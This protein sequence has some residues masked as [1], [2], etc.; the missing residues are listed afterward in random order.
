MV[1]ARGMLTGS[2][3]NSDGMQNPEPEETLRRAAGWSLVL[4][5]LFIAY[6]SLYPFEFDP[7]RLRSADAQGWLASFAWRRPVR[8]DLIANLLFYLPFGA[9]TTYLAPQRWSNLRRWMLALCTGTALSLFIECAQFATRDRVPALSDVA[10]NGLS[11][12]LASAAVLGAHGLGVR[13]TLPQLRTHRPDPIALLLVALWLAFHCA[14]FMPT[15]RFLRYFN[16]PDLLLGQSVPVSATA[17][18]F[19]GY[20]IIGAALRNLLRPSSFWPVMASVAAVSLFARIAFRGQQLELAECVGLALALPLVWSI[21]RDAESQVYLK[22]AF[23]AATAVVVFMLAPFDFSSTTPTLYGIPI[24]PL[25][26]RTAGYEPGLLE[27]SF[28]YLGCV[29]LANEA[30]LR[31]RDVAP[32]ILGAAL[33]IEFIQVWQPGRGAHVSAPLAVIISTI[34]VRARRAVVASAISSAR[35]RS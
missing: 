31:L 5:V 6:A 8:S 19:A 13:A 4:T 3:Y 10:I 33:L 16:N 21:S 18:Y 34:L 7:H 12:A 26:H 35:R 20:V 27:M 28:L 22:A 2:R 29:W 24:L 25:A 17:G 14:P 1:G 23:W 11:A 9:L 30:G 15:A 32:W